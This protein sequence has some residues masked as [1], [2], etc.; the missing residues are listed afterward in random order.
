MRTKIARVLG[1]TTAVAMLGL[2]TAAPATAREPIGD[3]RR[4]TRQIDH[5]EDVLV[6][7]R[8]RDNA[9]W[10][11]STSD[12]IERLMYKRAR[13]CPKYAEEIL[14]GEGAQK[15]AYE[16]GRFFKAAGKVAIRYFTMGAW[17]P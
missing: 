17:S 7:A 13:L 6:M 12:H 4:L 3:C 8:E 15:F 16:A 9:L 11:E 14:A 2:A 1:L 5:F 10:A